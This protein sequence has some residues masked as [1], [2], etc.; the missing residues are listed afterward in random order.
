MFET[1]PHT[2]LVVT[3]RN[4]IFRAFSHW[5]MERFLM[6]GRDSRETFQDAVIEE[7]QQGLQDPSCL[8]A[9]MA[10][11]KLEYCYPFLKELTYRN[12]IQLVGLHPYL[13]IGIYHHQLWRWLQ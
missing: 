2:K 12:S 4:P 1:A 7:M 8:E 13:A 9:E 5:R 3:V 10:N 11:S 6:E